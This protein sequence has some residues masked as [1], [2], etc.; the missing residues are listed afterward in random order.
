MENLR[1]GIVGSGGIARKFVRDLSVARAGSVRAVVSRDIGRARAAAREFAAPLALSDVRALAAESSV[2]I[3]YIATPHCAHFGAAQILLS[4]GKAVLAEK[5][6]TVNAA[7]ARG[8]VALARA[9]GAFLMEAIWPRFSPLYLRLGRL[10]G[11]GRIGRLRAVTS[12]FCVRGNLD[13]AQ[14]WMNPALAGGALLDLGIYCLAMSQFV[15]REEP[16]D[17]A[18]VA[19]MSPTGVDEILSASLGYPSGAVAN[20]VCSLVA[21]GDNRLVVAGEHGRIEVPAHFIAA[22]KAIVFAGDTSEVIDEPFRGEG[23]EYEI[24]EAARCLR[25]GLTESP[26]MPWADTLAL[27]ETMDAIRRQ[28]ALRYPFE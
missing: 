19:R 8:L 5:P 11:D 20:F 15:L 10:I 9:N 13:P 22:E 16:S 21:H 2:D 24:E 1:W 26:L 23:F 25:A 27:A 12:G 4:C 28:I 6:L 3:V 7:Q 18:A 17:L 14:R